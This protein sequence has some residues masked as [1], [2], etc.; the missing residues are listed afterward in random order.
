MNNQVCMWG[1][2]K[3]LISCRSVG[4]QHP[5]S[6]YNFLLYSLLLVHCHSCWL[7]IVTNSWESLRQVPVR[8]WFQLFP[9]FS[10]CFLHLRMLSQLDLNLEFLQQTQSVNMLFVCYTSR[11]CVCV[12]LMLV[13]NESD[14]WI[15]R[16]VC[17]DLFIYMGSFL[18]SSKISPLPISVALLWVGVR[19]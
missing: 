16:S 1:Y 9:V 5:A 19:K 12:R 7:L 6:W 18:I 2:E 4:I 3:S 15:C 13:Y 10:F 14:N 11:A 17:C 8:V